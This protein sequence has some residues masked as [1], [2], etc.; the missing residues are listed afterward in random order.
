MH[1]NPHPDHS[2][3]AHSLGP[4]GRRA[5]PRASHATARLGHSPRG[6][7]GRVITAGVRRSLGPLVEDGSHGQ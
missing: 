1:G 2:Q 6:D 5:T 7:Q 4:F 3:L